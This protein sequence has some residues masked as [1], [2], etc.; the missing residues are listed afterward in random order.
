M[1]R[2]RKILLILLA[3]ILV[4]A[5]GA[6][7]FQREIRVAYHKNG[8]RTASRYCQLANPSGAFEPVPPPTLIERCGLGFGR[9]K[10]ERELESM[11]WHTAA[12]VKL[13]YF[14]EETFPLHNRLYVSGTNVA[15]F[16]QLLKERFDL[17][18]PQSWTN[19]WWDMGGTQSNKIVVRTTPAQMPKWKKLV[20]DFDEP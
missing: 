17:G 11:N 6:V 4:A 18:K 5:V 13:G 14:V 19:D 9:G 2:R 20:E 10:Y 1:S 16:S 15:M 3:V 8:L 7:V 12:L